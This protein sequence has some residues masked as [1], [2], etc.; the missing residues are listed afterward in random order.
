MWILDGYN[1]LFRM[2]GLKGTLEQ[3]RERLLLTIRERFPLREITIVFDGRLPPPDHT[4]QHRG[5][6]EV[7]YTPEGMTADSWIIDKLHTT[8]HPQRYLVVTGDRALARM[9]AAS[10]ARVERPDRW[11]RDLAQDEPLTPVIRLPRSSREYLDL[12]EERWAKML[13]GDRLEDSD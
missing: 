2:P 11:L 4:R 3:R 9:A 12:F 10:G 13:R 8:L 7:I 5:C 6:V 1:L